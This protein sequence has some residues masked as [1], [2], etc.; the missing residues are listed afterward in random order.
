LWF[1]LLVGDGIVIRTAAEP[2]GND[3]EVNQDGLAAIQLCEDR[4]R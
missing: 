4:W 2:V 3:S 1:F